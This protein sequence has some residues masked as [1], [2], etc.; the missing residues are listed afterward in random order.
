MTHLLVQSWMRPEISSI[1]A[2][3]DSFFEY[4]LKWYIMSGTSTV[5]RPGN[6]T[7]EPVNT[8]EVEFLDVWQEAYAAI[9]RYVRAPDGFWVSTGYSVTSGI[10]PDSAKYRSVNIHTVSVHLVSR[11]THPASQ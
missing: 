3:I 8:G 5:L 1:G 10:W 9:M 4:A 7:A 6:S 11:V 2:G